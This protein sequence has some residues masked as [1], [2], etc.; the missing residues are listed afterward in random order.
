MT[1]D[2]QVRLHSD[3]SFGHYSGKTLAIAF[4][5]HGDVYF[6]AEDF[7]C[8]IADFEE[9]IR[10]NPKDADGFDAAPTPTE[11]RRS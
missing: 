9:P 7:N 6:D 1:P 4:A 10:L 3:H 5:K 8:A 2:M 11:T